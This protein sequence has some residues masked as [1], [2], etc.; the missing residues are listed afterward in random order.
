M[1]KPSGKA[2]RSIC[3]I[4]QWGTSLPD[5][6]PWGAVK[7]REGSGKALVG[8]DRSAVGV[9]RVLEFRSEMCL[10]GSSVAGLV[11]NT[12]VFGG[13]AF[14]SDWTGRALTS[15]VE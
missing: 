11:P 5:Q 1:P 2:Y 8:Y 3:K 10:K 13:G 15:S 6:G 12:G 9:R 4:Q 14:G 7:V